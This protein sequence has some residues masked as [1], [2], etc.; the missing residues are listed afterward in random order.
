VAR[1]RLPVTGTYKVRR[2]GRTSGAPAD[3]MANYNRAIQNALDNVNWPVGE[4]RG[5]TLQ[6]SATIKVTNPGTIIEYCATF[7]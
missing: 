1:K 2:S 5:A 7:I 6:L 4:H 3:H